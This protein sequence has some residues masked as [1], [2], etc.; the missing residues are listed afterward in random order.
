MTARRALWNKQ[1]SERNPRAPI[2]Q[3]RREDTAMSMI[4]TPK[5]M[6]AMA[7]LFIAAMVLLYG[8]I[9]TLSI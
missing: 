3:K 4:L 9:L 1:T 5:S 7:L 8:D 6:L 2:L